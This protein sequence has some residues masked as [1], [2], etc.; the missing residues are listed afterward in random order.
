[1]KC[2]ACRFCAPKTRG[3]RCSKHQWDVRP[4]S[5]HWA[6]RVNVYAKQSFVI[7]KIEQL[8]DHGSSRLVQ[9]VQKRAP[10]YRWYP[11][12]PD[13]GGEATLVQKRIYDNFDGRGIVY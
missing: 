9:H 10:L 13:C 4:S 1:M 11:V 8:T 3:F 7:N 2:D 12:P 6:R 5:D